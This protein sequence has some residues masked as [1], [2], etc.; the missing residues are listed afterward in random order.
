MKKLSKTGQ[1]VSELHLQIFEPMMNEL[2][3]MGYDV[4][5]NLI[6]DDDKQMVNIALES[7]HPSVEVLNVVTELYER[8]FRMYNN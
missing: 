2:A 3:E 1:M 8:Y 5:V 6:W 4:G 7:N